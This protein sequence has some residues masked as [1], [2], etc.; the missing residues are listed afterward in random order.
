MTHCKKL[1]HICFTE[2]DLLAE[3][4]GKVVFGL[5]SVPQVFETQSLQEAQQTLIIYCELSP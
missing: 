5:L 4:K 1:E 2:R 3:D